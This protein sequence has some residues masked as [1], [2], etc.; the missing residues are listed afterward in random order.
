VFA[1]SM[2]DDS[3]EET[4]VLRYNA[5][6]NF[7]D[8]GSKFWKYYYVNNDEDAKIGKLTVHGAGLMGDY[9]ADGTWVTKYKYVVD[10][11]EFLSDEYHQYLGIWGGIAMHPGDKADVILSFVSPVEGVIDISANMKAMRSG[12]DGVRLYT[13]LNSLSL[14]NK[15]YPEDSAYLFHTSAGDTQYALNGLNVKRGDEILFRLNKNNTLGNDF[16]YFSPTVE[17]QSYVMPEDSGII[18]SKDSFAIPVGGIR[19]LEA[20]LNIDLGQP[21]NYEFVSSDESVAIVDEY[22]LIYGIK[23]GTAEITVTEKGS[24]HS[25][26]CS[27]VIT[28]AKNIQNNNENS[29][30]LI[31]VVIASVVVAIITTVIIV[32]IKK[33]KNDRWLK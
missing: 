21:L 13:T 1:E 24:G 20:N 19:L 30:D 32:F 31:V 29:K 7:S 25:E 18:I 2:P 17:Y 11:R 16:T 4:T 27:V 12:S 33:R 14:E 9:T 15:V 8:M 28:Q 10:V 6:E 5:E 23:E 26:K 22:G 3:F